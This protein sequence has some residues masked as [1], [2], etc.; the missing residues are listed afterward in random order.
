MRFLQITG[1]AMT[2]PSR[3][4][5]IEPNYGSAWSRLGKIT[6]GK[7]NSG[8]SDDFTHIGRSGILECT[9]RIR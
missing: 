2:L 8:L 7:G 1:L 4:A 5:R 9:Y 6:N 3:A